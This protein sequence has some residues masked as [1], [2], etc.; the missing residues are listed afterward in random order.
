MKHQENTWINVSHFGLAAAILNYPL[1]NACDSFIGIAL[2]SKDQ[3]R[4]QEYSSRY[5]GSL[6]LSHAGAEIGPHVIPAWRPPSLIL[7][8]QL[9]VAVLG[10]TPMN[11]IIFKFVE[12]M[13]CQL[14]YKG[15]TFRLH[16]I[17]PAALPL[18]CCY[19]FAHLG[20]GLTIVS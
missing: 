3:L 6:L 9:H 15:N 8:F 14:T 17:N 12:R 5:F 13:S 7:H 20:A 16:G 18:V 11:R 10:I 1:P 4:K 19:L 2:L